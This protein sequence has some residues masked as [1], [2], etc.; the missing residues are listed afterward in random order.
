MTGRD[1]TI[2][3]PELKKYMDECGFNATYRDRFNRIL[4]FYGY[5]ATQSDVVRFL[6]M[7]VE[8]E[9]EYKRTDEI[10]SKWRKPKSVSDTFSSIINVCNIPEVKER[11]GDRH[12]EVVSAHDAYIKVL[13][14]AARNPEPRTISV[15]SVP[16]AVADTVGYETLTEC[17]DAVNESQ[18]EYEVG[19]EDESEE[20]IAAKTGETE[21]TGRIEE[22]EKVL[23]SAHRM[24][25]YMQSLRRICD[26]MVDII[27]DLMEDE[28]SLSPAR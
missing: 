6:S 24:K 26:A 19:C 28:F 2:R 13:M 3:L 27:V 23:V 21:K 18:K 17:S 11:L 22:V 4:K 9:Q 10:V 5:T 1:E 14:E 25:V 8:K 15:I 16:E 20:H 12:I 7:I